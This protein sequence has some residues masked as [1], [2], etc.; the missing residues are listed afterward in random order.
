MKT[1]P[2]LSI[3]HFLKVTLGVILISAGIIG[4]LVPFVPGTL[5]V[6]GGLILIGYTTKDIKKIRLKNILNKFK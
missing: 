4:W 5:L 1:K 2:N 6:I 3:K